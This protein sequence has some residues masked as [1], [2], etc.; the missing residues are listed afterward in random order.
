MNAPR[1]TSPAPVVSTTSTAGAGTWYD[2][3]AVEQQRTA[4]RPA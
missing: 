3:I 1:K 4:A 2:A